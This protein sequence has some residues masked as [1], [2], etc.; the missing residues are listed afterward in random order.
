MP[1]V[2]EEFGRYRKAV[3]KG[4]D[5]EYTFVRSHLKELAQYIIPQRYLS[6]DEGK[7]T[8]DKE[9]NKYILDGHATMSARTLSSGMFYGATNPTHRW[10]VLSLGDQRV[11]AQ[12]WKDMIVN[13]TLKAIGRS[14]IYN[15]LPTT[16]LDLGVFGT[17]AML[18]YED[19]E[20]LFRAYNLPAG[21]YRVMKDAR[22]KISYLSR[23]FR[24]T[25]AQLVDRF[26]IENVT[27]QARRMYNNPTGNK[28]KE[29]DVYHLIEPNNP[30]TLPPEFHFRECYWEK[31]GPPNM[32]LEIAGYFEKPFIAP[33]WEVVGNNTYG[34]SPGMDA[35]PDII[36]LQHLTR[37]RAQGL[38]K[39]VSPSIV[40]DQSLRNQPSA[41]MPNGITYVPSASTVGAKPIYQ[42]QLPYNE[43]R[44]DK[45]SYYEAIDRFFYTDLFRAILDIRTVRS[46]TEIAEKA[47]EKLV[48]LGPV[49][50][51]V[52]DEALHDM[53]VRVMGIMQRAGAY[54]P[55]PPLMDTQM[56]IEYDSIL[57]AAQKAAGINNIERFLSVTGQILPV[58]PRA[59][60]V[61]SWNETLR[62]YADR[63]NIPARLLNTREEV[64]RLD[65]Q[66]DQAVEEERQAAIA[67]DL[68]AATQSLSDANA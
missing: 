53:I 45:I 49:V 35:L 60:N 44:D 24:M 1:Q 36:G 68:G 46:A 33:R 10:L 67:R 13:T 25:A 7:K 61:V 59:A 42:L 50:G 8:N 9:R 21:E 3:L 31:G 17:T 30:P 62:E 11:A 64:A 6:L 58:A 40:M 32:A 38:D 54:P 34:V 57:S 65:Q 22:G 5:D 56:S 26:G 2:S 4:M 19:N 16:Y 20:T 41:L 51:R 29:F 43:L 28:F 66:Q 39:Q 47:A 48:L 63:L 23:E 15:A 37:K 52:E 14:N 18:I 55:P 12:R 27:E